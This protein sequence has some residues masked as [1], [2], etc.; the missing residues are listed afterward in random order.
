MFF[1]CFALICKPVSRFL[2]SLQGRRSPSSKEREGKKYI[3]WFS[4]FVPHLL[5]I[6][7]PRQ[8]PRCASAKRART[9]ARL[10]RQACAKR[11]CQL[12]LQLRT[13]SLRGQ[14]QN[15]RSKMRSFL[16]LCPLELQWAS[17]VYTRTLLC[18][19]SLCIMCSGCIRSIHFAVLGSHALCHRCGFPSL[20][21]R[22]KAVLAWVHVVTRKKVILACTQ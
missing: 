2:I 18:N 9:L 6:I 13:S 8:V 1:A 7:Q 22:T 14:V 11:V 21:T 20:G 17:F 19:S 4:L 15:L 10:S 12:Q 16:P 5:S 3:F